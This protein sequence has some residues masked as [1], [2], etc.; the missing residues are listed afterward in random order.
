MSYCCVLTSG[1]GPGHQFLSSLFLGGN[2]CC[3]WRL[4]GFCL[5]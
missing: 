3:W 1:P 4:L 2:L 5:F